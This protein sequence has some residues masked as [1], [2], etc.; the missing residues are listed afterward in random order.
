VSLPPVLGIPISGGC[1]TDK[2][3]NNGGPIARWPWNSIYK[4]CRGMAVGVAAIGTSERSVEYAGLE[5]IFAGGATTSTLGLKATTMYRAIGD[6]TK[7]VNH[8]VISA[9]HAARAIAQLRAPIAP[10]FWALH[11]EPKRFLSQSKRD[12]CQADVDLG[13]RSG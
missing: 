6:E 7:L 2:D 1:S 8:A 3:S 12:G 5:K 10:Q 4:A 9:G 13:S 11:R